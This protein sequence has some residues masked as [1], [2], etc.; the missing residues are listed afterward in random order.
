MLHPSPPASNRSAILANARLRRDLP[1]S[2]ACRGVAPRNRART[3]RGATPCAPVFITTEPPRSQRHVR[4][5]MPPPRCRPTARP[6]PLP[7]RRD[8]RP[9]LHPRP[10]HRAR[11]AP[12]QPDAESGR[13]MLAL[14]LEQ[15]PDVPTTPPISDRL[16]SRGDARR[17]S[18]WACGLALPANSHVDGPSGERW[19]RERCRATCAKVR[20]GPST[21][22]RKGT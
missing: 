15:S 19:T 1:L 9:R 13:S 5:H 16:Q 22:A 7:P 4:T 17:L 14:L 10:P 2:A 8:R 6:R 3:S 12:V 21:S 18:R 20:Q 11:A